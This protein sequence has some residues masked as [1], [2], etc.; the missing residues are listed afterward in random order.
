MQFHSPRRAVK[1]NEP[2]VRQVAVG[3]SIGAMCRRCKGRTDH[4]VVAKLGVKPTRV[5]CNAC[6][7]THDYGAS[8]RVR[9]VERTASEPSWADVLSRASGPATPYSVG[10]TYRIGARVDHATFGQ[11]VVMRF[12]S[13][14]VCEVLFESRTVKLLMAPVVSSLDLPEPREA[15]AGGRRRRR[16]G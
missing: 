9:P 15:R 4:T 12:A 3:S 11:G 6:S 8:V 16:L 2:V 5:R 1:V 7:D 14:T 10:G 13:T